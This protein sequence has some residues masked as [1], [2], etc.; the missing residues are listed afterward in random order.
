MQVVD[1][2]WFLTPQAF[3]LFLTLDVSFFLLLQINMYFAVSFFSCLQQTWIRRAII[4]DG[5]SCEATWSY[6]G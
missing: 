6:P 4:W 5:V 1:L 3:F 2:I